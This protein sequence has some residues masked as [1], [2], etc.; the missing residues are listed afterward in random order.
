M[1][2]TMLYKYNRTKGSLQLPVKSPRIKHNFDYVIVDDA[3]VNEFMA[4]GWYQTP[5]EALEKSIN[6][7]NKKE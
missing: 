6:T 1:S 4:D 2:K 3:S 5:K 7:N